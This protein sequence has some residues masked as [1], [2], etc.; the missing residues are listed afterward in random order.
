MTTRAFSQEGSP[1]ARLLSLEVPK[2]VIDEA[3]E[4]SE[5]DPEQ[6]PP[7]TDVWKKDRGE[8]DQTKDPAFF[9]SLKTTA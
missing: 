6:D 8:A 3:G 5:K 2:T 9:T 7:R 1:P 4:T